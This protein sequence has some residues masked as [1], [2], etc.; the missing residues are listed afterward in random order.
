MIKETKNVHSGLFEFSSMRWFITNL[1]GKS[2][3]LPATYRD[4]LILASWPPLAADARFTQ[5][6]DHF[7]ADPCAVLLGIRAVCLTIADIFFA[8]CAFLGQQ[9]F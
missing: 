2:N 6:R 5:P 3:Y 8:R 4:R 9:R 7:L 1:D